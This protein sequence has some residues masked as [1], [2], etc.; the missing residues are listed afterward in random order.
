IYHG[1]CREDPTRFNTLFIKQKTFEAHLRFYKKHWNL[2]TLDDFYQGN[3]SKDR[4]NLCLT[5]DDGFAN[6]YKYVLPL[7]EKYEIP[8]TFFVTAIRKEGYNILWNDFLTISSVT[9]PQKLVFN[10]ERFSKQKG[11]TYIS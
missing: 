5:F 3:F 1:I 6:N 9:G 10:N 2:L 8:A 7:L 4:F 11:R